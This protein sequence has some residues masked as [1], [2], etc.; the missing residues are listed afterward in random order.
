M[1][2]SDGEIVRPTRKA[3]ADL[4]IGVPPIETPLHDVDDPHVREMQKL[5]Q[6][7]ESGGAEPIRKIRDRVVFKYKSSNVR[8]AVTRLAAV[9]L[10][11]GFIELGRIGRWWIIAAGYRKKDSPNEDFYAQLPATSDGLLPTDWDYKR[12]SAELANRW[13]DVVSSTVRR[14]IKTSLETGKPAAATAVNHY[15]EAR[16]SDGDEVYLTVGTGGVYDPKVI[17]VI[18]D[19]VPGVAHEDWFIEPSVE[20]GIQPSTG[21]VVWSTMLPTT[22][23]EQLLSDID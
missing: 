15:I 22:T 1:P 10:P 8:A 3:L 14:L 19:S 23:R 6:Y 4:N 12:L 2:T 20:L 21:E 16:V 5:P 9:D 13:V 7:F 17:A 18:L 11:T